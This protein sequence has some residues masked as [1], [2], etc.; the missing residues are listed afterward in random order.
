MFCISVIIVIQEESGLQRT[1]VGTADLHTANFN[2]LQKAIDQEIRRMTELI[3]EDG[4]HRIVSISHSVF[5][6]Y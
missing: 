1:R 6:S 4:K 2:Q 3:T 5:K